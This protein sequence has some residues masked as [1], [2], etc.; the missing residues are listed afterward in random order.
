[1]LSP[2]LLVAR[3]VSRNEFLQSEDA[4][5][6]YWKEWRNLQAKQV[7]RWETLI[8]RDEV[9]AKHACDPDFNGEVHFGYLFGIMVEKGSEFHLGDARRYYKYRV[10]FQGNNV[11]DQNWDVALFNEMASTPATME[12][13][14][15]ADMD[16]G[17][18]TKG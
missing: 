12:A 11:R 3:S 5:A 7:W 8:E 1:M 6:A 16:Q 17:F 13:S 9:A 14:R 4:L 15:I 18:K 10:V 2:S